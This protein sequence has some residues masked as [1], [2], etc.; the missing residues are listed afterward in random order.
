MIAGVV[1]VARL[2]KGQESRGDVLAQALFS[3][4]GEG[5]VGLWCD[6]GNGRFLLPFVSTVYV[7]HLSMV[8]CLLLLLNVV[9]TMR[10]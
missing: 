2:V 10:Y 7:V 1:L 3:R 5:W 9:G 8:Y 4:F 6:C